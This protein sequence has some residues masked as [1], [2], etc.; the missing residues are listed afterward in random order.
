MKIK[1]NRN[2]LIAM[3]MLAGTDASRYVLNGI[4]IEVTKTRCILTATDGRRLGSI[5]EGEVI[6]P[7]EKPTSFIVAI[8]SAILKALPKSSTKAC[9]PGDI[10][11]S[12]NGDGKTV[13]FAPLGKGEK[14]FSCECIEGN[15][16]K[17]R[18]VVPKGNLATPVDP[19]FNWR[20]L[21][22]FTKAAD[23]L[24]GRRDTGIQM[25]QSDNKSPMLVF[26]KSRPE[27]V[28]VLMP[29]HMPENSSCAPDW[30]T[31]EDDTVETPAAT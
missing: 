27:F 25:R 23:M 7:P 1:I 10:I 16:P 15:Y 8:D 24:V 2:T 17:W 29:M 12:M 19:C 30:A 13:S 31:K 18:Q 9:H 4:N 6:E 11:L 22:G 20:L 5:C 21:E 14:K 26:I 3:Q 28:G